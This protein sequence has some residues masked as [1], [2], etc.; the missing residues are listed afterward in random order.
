MSLRH[1]LC[2]GRDLVQRILRQAEHDRA[3]RSEDGKFQSWAI[4]GGSDIVRNMDVTRDGTPVTA[5]S[6]ANQVGKIEIN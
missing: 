1:D 4:P 2:E 3:L 6:L 5:H